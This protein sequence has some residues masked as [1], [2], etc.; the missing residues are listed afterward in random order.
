[1]K[2]LDI[3]KLKYSTN[4]F[5]GHM[6]ND[7]PD[8][9]FWTSDENMPENIRKELTRIIME[10]NTNP[11][12]K[13]NPARQLHSIEDI[14]SCSGSFSYIHQNKFSGEFIDYFYDKL[15]L[16][17]MLSNPNILEST[18]VKFLNEKEWTEEKKIDLITKN[19][20]ALKHY[21]NIKNQF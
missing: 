9:A 16:Y 12:N 1:M 20:A 17:D 2:N 21:E 18:V 6:V 5:D 11:W 14:N 7:L 8:K 10:W 4:E 13:D 15:D 19:P 3:A